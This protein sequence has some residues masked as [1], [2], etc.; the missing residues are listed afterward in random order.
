MTNLNVRFYE[1]LCNKNEFIYRECK[2]LKKQKHLTECYI[3][4]GFVKIIIK[5]GD[6][7]IKINH[8]DDLYDVFWDYYNDQESSRVQ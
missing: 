3:R 5:E 8:P 7:P 2:R 4:N 6:N 1:N